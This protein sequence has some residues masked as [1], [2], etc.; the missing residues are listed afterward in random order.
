MSVSNERQIAIQMVREVLAKDVFGEKSPEKILT[1]MQTI[2][3][4]PK[5]ND[6]IRNWDGAFLV[7]RNIK[8]AG[9]LQIKG[10]MLPKSNL[11]EYYKLWAKKKNLWLESAAFK[12]T[13]PQVGDIFVKITGDE[14]EVA[15]VVGYSDLHLMTIIGQGTS[16]QHKNYLLADINAQ[17]GVIHWE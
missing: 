15:L 11:A 10:L 17:S 2:N 6:K 3:Q 7:H 14:S 13:T 4:M 5:Q 1:Y 9:N 8:A 16:V 12:T